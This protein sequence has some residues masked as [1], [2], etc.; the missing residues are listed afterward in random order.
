M[1]A[2]QGDDEAEELT[3]AEAK[4]KAEGDISKAATVAVNKLKAMDTPMEL[5]GERLGF[6][7]AFLQVLLSQG[8]ADLHLTHLACN[9][10]CW[11]G[12][13]CLLSLSALAAGLISLVDCGASRLACWDH[14]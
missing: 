3:A 10:Q 12:V 2:E 1:T 7:T 9:L 11:R 6:E 8:N 5:G 13:T 4:L 14:K